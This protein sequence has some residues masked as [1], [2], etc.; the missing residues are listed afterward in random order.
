MSKAKPRKRRSKRS[1]K[2]ALHKWR[3]DEIKRIG[4]VIAKLMP[5][6]HWVEPD[7]KGSFE[8]EY[9]QDLSLWKLSNRRLD[10]CGRQ[11]C[12][13]YI[14]DHRI[15]RY[16]PRH[17]GWSLPLPVNV[18]AKYIHPRQLRDWRKDLQKLYLRL[19]R[20]FSAKSLRPVPAH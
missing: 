2:K 12:T 3:E 15:L 4:K 17:A 14:D 7:A 6:L 5:L 10:Q 9:E 19:K 18:G 11:L 13:C 1:S 16:E 20:R 8:H